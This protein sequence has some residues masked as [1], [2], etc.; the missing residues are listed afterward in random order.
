MKEP[1]ESN[2]QRA[3]TYR[4]LTNQIEGMC[5][6]EYIPNQITLLS[7][8]GLHAIV[9]SAHIA[10]IIVRLT[11]AIGNS[12]VMGF[13]KFKLTYRSKGPDG[14]TYRRMQVSWSTWEISGV[15]ST[16]TENTWRTSPP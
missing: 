10:C 11:A 8:N 3:T 7:N 15:E 1:E 14:K 9:F 5:G 4:S 2:G 16:E 12:D 6:T 13:Q